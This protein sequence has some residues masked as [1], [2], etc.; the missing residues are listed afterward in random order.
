MI[1]EGTNHEDNTKDVAEN[2]VTIYFSDFFRFTG[3]RPVESLSSSSSN[4]SSSSKKG[5][6]LKYIKPN[7]SWLVKSLK[8]FTALTSSKHVF[9]RSDQI[10]HFHLL[11]AFIPNKC[12]GTAFKVPLHFLYCSPALL[13]PLLLP[14]PKP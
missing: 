5:S 13:K 7:S 3:P 2:S 8:S 14:P 1:E 9:F 6:W 12:D 4:S 10:Y 11:C